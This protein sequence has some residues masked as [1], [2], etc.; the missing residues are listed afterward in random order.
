MYSKKIV[1]L[2]STTKKTRVKLDLSKDQRDSLAVLLKKAL[3]GKVTPIYPGDT[4]NDI[5]RILN[6]L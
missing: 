1:G 3:N 4:Y 5:S 6:K 2:G